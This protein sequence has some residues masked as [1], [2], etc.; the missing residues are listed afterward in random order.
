[1][2]VVSQELLNHS[3]SLSDIYI[4]YTDSTHDT[5]RIVYTETTNEV[6]AMDVYTQYSPRIIPG[7]KLIY[8]MDY[9]RRNVNHA[10]HMISTDEFE[11]TYGSFWVMFTK[12]FG[13]SSHI[14]TFLHIGQ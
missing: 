9:D 3:H 7:G 6:D 12:S 14:S 13:S 8:Y 2:E 11:M 5:Y 1:M 4:V 10:L